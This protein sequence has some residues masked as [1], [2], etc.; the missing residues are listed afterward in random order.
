[1]VVENVEGVDRQAGQPSTNWANDNLDP[2]LCRYDG[3]L[4]GI[5]TDLE[6]VLYRSGICSVHILSR[7]GQVNLSHR[8]H[9]DR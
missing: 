6:S 1:M 4:G 3:V 2:N 5:C 8:A 7:D 9:H